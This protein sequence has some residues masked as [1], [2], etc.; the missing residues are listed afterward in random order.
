MNF[1]NRAILSHQYYFIIK[2]TM[3]LLAFEYLCSI[4]VYILGRALAKM[5]FKRL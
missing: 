3:V 1:N 4:T 5:L 2:Q